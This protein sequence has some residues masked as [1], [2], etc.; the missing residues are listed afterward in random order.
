VVAG[1]AAIVAVLDIPKDSLPA[2]EAAYPDW[3]LR[4]IQRKPGGQS[5]FVLL[6][7]E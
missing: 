5:Q 4:M 3:K 1:R 6:S 7:N 2:V